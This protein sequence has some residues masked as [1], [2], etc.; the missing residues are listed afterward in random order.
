MT[1]GQLVS[2]VGFHD[3]EETPGKHSRICLG[4]GQGLLTSGTQS[5]HKELLCGLCKR[6]AYGRC[7]GGFYWLGTGAENMYALLIFENINT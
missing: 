7:R 6:E 2:L 4:Y 3:M 1:D 5:A